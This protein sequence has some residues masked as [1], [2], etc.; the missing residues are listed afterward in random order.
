MSF[1]SD[2]SSLALE[3]AVAEC[4]GLDYLFEANFRYPQEIFG[5]IIEANVT[6]AWGTFA[7]SR[8]FSDPKATRGA[9]DR[10]IE[11]LPA[12]GFG[13]GEL[14]ISISAG[15]QGE[16]A[17]FVH[18]FGNPGRAKLGGALLGKK[19]LPGFMLLGASMTDSLCR[20]EIAGVFYV[21]DAATNVG[22]KKWYQSR[23]DAIYQAAGLY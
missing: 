11:R 2:G 20:L 13:T 15:S 4:F 14:L 16:I 21:P 17:V 9:L 12:S 6:R 22:M 10:A 1:T 5:E 19:H 23:A 3:E 8:N 18:E 7:K